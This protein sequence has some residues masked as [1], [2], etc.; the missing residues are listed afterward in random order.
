[1]V[2]WYLYLFCMYIVQKS[3]SLVLRWYLLVLYVQKSKS[4]VVRWYLLVLYVHGVL[5]VGQAVVVHEAEEREEGPTSG[6]TEHDTVRLQN[7]CTIFCE[8]S[9]PVTILRF[10]SLAQ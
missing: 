1:M 5:G 2:R 7:S 8:A 3:N 4:L 10:Y 9:F 6:L